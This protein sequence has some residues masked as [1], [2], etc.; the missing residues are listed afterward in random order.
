MKKMFLL[1][2]AVA[3]MAAPALAQTP[4]AG[5]QYSDAI[6]NFQINATVANFCRFGSAGNT[7]NVGTNGVSVG[8]DSNGNGLTTGDQAFVVDIQKDSDNTVQAASGAFNYAQAQCNTPYTVTSTSQNSGLLSSY[9]G[10]AD[11]AFVKTVPYQIA[12]S[13]G[14]TAS[15][16]QPVAATNTLIAS[17]NPFASSARFFFSIPASGSLLLAGTYRDEVRLTMSPLTGG[18]SI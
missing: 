6:S 10:T 9:T 7:A 12:F 4:G 5:T 16:L 18:P 15:G 13:A 8:P 3:M 14:S 2:T 11:A 17:G 1:A